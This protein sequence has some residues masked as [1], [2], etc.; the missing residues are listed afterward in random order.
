[1][2]SLLERF[3]KN[4]LPCNSFMDLKFRVIPF[5]F[6]IFCDFGK[7]LA[8]I[9]TVTFYSYFQYLTIKPQYPKFFVIVVE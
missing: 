9:F 3:H 1:M 6:F 8:N 5:Q 4:N 7:I 2:K